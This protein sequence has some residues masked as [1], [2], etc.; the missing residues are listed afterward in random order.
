MVGTNRRFLKGI[1][2]SKRKFCYAIDKGHWD[3]HYNSSY[4]SIYC[5]LVLK[6][7]DQAETEKQEAGII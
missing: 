6:Q 4:H 1:E 5:Y 7:E 3:N 2:K